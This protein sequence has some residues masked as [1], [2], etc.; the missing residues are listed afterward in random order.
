METV[1]HNRRQRGLPLV[2]LPVR[3]GF[4]RIGRGGEAMVLLF[5]LVLWATGSSSL[6]RFADD[7]VL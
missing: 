4:L 7:R 2:E 5:F 1:G 6:G 3:E